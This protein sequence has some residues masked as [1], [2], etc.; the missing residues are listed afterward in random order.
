MP[1]TI[2]KHRNRRQTPQLADFHG[3]WPS[4]SK[5]SSASTLF[6]RCK[7]PVGIGITLNIKKKQISENPKF[8]KKSELEKNITKCK[9]S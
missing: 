6:K 8:W 1:K 4:P 5:E 2:E 7:L 9:K 3:L